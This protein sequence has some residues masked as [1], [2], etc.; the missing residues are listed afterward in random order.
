MAEPAAPDAQKPEEG[1]QDDGQTYLI[2]KDVCPDM[3]PGDEMVVKIVA[4][5]DKEYEVSYAPEGE[6]SEEKEA[7]GSEGMGATMPEGG[8]G[9]GEA[10]GGMY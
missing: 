3:K 1:K 4:I 10:G 9:G 2:N 6:H 7:A 8:A 5:H